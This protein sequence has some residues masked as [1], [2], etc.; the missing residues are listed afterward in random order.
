MQN[1][2]I[3]N[4]VITLH[5]RGWT[6]RRISRELGIS[7]ERVTRILR[8]NNQKRETGQIMPQKTTTKPS[9]LDPYKEYISELLDKY[10]QPPVTTQRV[11][12]KIREKGYQGGRTILGEYVASIR[13]KQAGEPVVYVETAPGQRGS[14]DWSEYHVYFTDSGT[15]EKVIFFSF[16]L[17]Y[18][19]RQYIEV[20]NDKTQTTLLRCLVSTFIYFDGVTREVKSDNQK[21]CVDRW[22][23]GKPVFN[24]RFL[25]FASWYRFKPLTINPGKPRENLRIERPFYYLEQNFLNGR[26][27]CNLQDLK[28]QLLVWLQGVND[29]RVHRTTG[30]TPL[31]MY[32]K[33][34][35]FLQP[36]PASHYDTSQTGYR[37]VNNESCVEWNGFSY[38]VPAPYMHQMCLVRES[39]DQVHI[40]G[41]CGSEIIRHALPP[42]NA[43]SKYVGRPALPPRHKASPRLEEVKLRLEDMGEVMAC[44]VQEIIKHKP[45]SYRHHLRRVLGLKVNYHR[46]DIILAVARALKYKVYESGAIEN[47]LDSYAEKKN[48]YR[49]FSKNDPV[50][51][52]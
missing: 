48:E 39:Q 13:G 47:F 16:I 14:H 24:R 6:I 37:V 52:K 30:E 21:A 40:Y 10:R 38:A 34:Y 49:L 25:E 11:L 8:R 22:E 43:A 35:P 41:P 17:N 51:E 45:S 46:Q 44:Y 19:R 7:R 18:C 36:L 3:E 33:E 42:K 5:A 1:E 32:Q 4:S 2:S 29:L 15:K 9:K 27:F 26:S 31:N 50:N 12:E 20:V 23:Q 28:D